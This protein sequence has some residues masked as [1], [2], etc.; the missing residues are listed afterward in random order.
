M[1]QD[2]TI[3]WE[4]RVQLA[5]NAAREGTVPEITV[6]EGDTIG[7]CNG[8]VMIAGVR[9]TIEE[10]LNTSTAAAA[11]NAEAAKRRSL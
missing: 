4:Y 5:L 1:A 8:Q 9:L 10:G 7:S 3:N 2:L 6:A 11:K